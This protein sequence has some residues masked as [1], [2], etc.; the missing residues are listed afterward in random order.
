M[1]SKEVIKFRKVKWKRIYCVP[2]HGRP[3][4]HIQKQHIALSSL[5]AHTLTTQSDLWVWH[6]I[7][8]DALCFLDTQPRCLHLQPVHCFNI[9]EYSGCGNTVFVYIVFSNVEN[10]IG[11]VILWGVGGDFVFKCR[12]AEVYCCN[13][14][15]MINIYSTVQ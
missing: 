2:F 6:V 4:A 8:S 13:F 5:A 7:V 3:L 10:Y 14:S 9:L 11:D 15:C 12:V 1:W